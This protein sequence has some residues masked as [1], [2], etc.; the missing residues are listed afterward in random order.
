MKEYRFSMAES[1]YD[2]LPEQRRLFIETYVAKFYTSEVGSKDLAAG[3]TYVAD[4]AYLAQE[5]IRKEN[6]KEAYKYAGLVATKLNFDD[7]ES[8]L[9][10][11]QAVKMLDEISDFSEILKMSYILI[12][13]SPSDS[14]P[15]LLLTHFQF[16]LENHSKAIWDFVGALETC[17][18]HIDKKTVFE[19]L[20]KLE[21]LSNRPEK[22]E[23]IYQVS[24]LPKLAERLFRATKYSEAIAIYDMQISKAGREHCIGVYAK[25]ADAFYQ[26]RNILLALRD[27]S[28]AIWLHQQYIGKTNFSIIDF[29]T[30]RRNVYLSMSKL[31]LSFADH[32]HI[33]VL[34]EE[35][36]AKTPNSFSK[37]EIENVNKEFSRLLLEKAKIQITNEK[38]DDALIYLN[39][40]LE[41]DRKNIFAQLEVGKIYCVEKNRSQAIKAFQTA[42]EINPLNDEAIK[43]LKLLGIK[44]KSA[45]EVDQRAASRKKRN[46]RKKAS[47]RAA[48][49]AE[50]ER[51]EKEEKDKKEAEE[52]RIAEEKRELGVI[53]KELNDEFFRKLDIDKII[54][55]AER[56]RILQ[57]KLPIEDFEKEI[58]LELKPHG[59]ARICGGTVRHRIKHGTI[60]PKKDVDVVVTVEPAKIMALFCKRGINPV[61]NSSGLFRFYVDCKGTT[62]KVDIWYSEKLK[63][64][65][66]VDAH[67][68]D[69]PSNALFMDEEGKLEDPT[70][71]G[72]TDILLEQI[73]TIRDPNV[74]FREDPLLVLRVPYTAYDSDSVMVPR[75]ACALKEAVIP[76]EETK[77]IGR[78]N[79]WM[80]KILA[81]SDAPEHFRE[82]VQKNI[83]I[84]L[85]TPTVSG[86]LA[87][88]CEWICHQLK[89][90]IVNLNKIYMNFVVSAYANLPKPKFNDLTK[91]IQDNP[92]LR[93]QFN[94][95]KE[96]FDELFENYRQ[97][98]KVF[99]QPS[100]VV[101]A[102]P[103]SK[104]NPKAK[105][106]TKPKFKL[107][108]KANEYKG[109]ETVAITGATPQTPYTEQNQASF[110]AKGK[111]VTKVTLP[112]GK[113]QP[114]RFELK[115]I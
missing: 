26:S 115:I 40:A 9:H 43:H 106:Y 75:V 82:L 67:S 11:L 72:I 102:K 35:L 98:R 8:A 50:I 19:M 5:N 57:T 16:K 45:E 103:K 20:D 64:S 30:K 76:L 111:V 14:R 32:D 63:E 95:E 22:K 86:A 52:R 109:K 104:L 46:A 38:N 34:I 69:C 65:L 12:K 114:I 84:K 15:R 51:K 58:L 54:L 107:N 1:R 110:Y 23:Q 60:N 13:K 66:E 74:C 113:L 37:E 49:E 41:L 42:L 85:F 83:L 94:M 24:E 97:A 2:S 101:A 73:D 77:D 3:G 91:I 28:V 21:P 53:A 100:N 96:E 27:Y 44:V 7:Y 108:P 4:L 79:A 55:N 62:R 56:N 81:D 89:T 47:T 93:I 68:R 59:R 10:Y 90:K 92:L 29:V 39:K 25:R 71:R 87:Q 18:P 33:F 70:G 80:L 17:D 36:N 99:Y 61:E 48:R 31:A 78:F 105:E 88:D 6:W 112:E